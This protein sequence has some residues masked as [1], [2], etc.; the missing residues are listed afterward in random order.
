MIQAPQE[1]RRRN[2]GPPGLTPLD[3]LSCNEKATFAGTPGGEDL[4]RLMEPQL[5]KE[6]GRQDG[7]RREDLRPHL[8][9]LQ[10]ATMRI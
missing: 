6:I 3:T 8:Q 4:W 10:Q 7:H 2:T 5:N 9:E 1:Y